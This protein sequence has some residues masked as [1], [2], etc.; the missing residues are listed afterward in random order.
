MN[1]ASF[2]TFIEL[3]ETISNDVT[4]AESTRTAIK[5]TLSDSVTN[6]MDYLN[7]GIYQTVSH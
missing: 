1:P 3:L 5:S 6:L 7:Y 2:N 4:A